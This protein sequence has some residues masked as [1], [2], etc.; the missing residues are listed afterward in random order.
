MNSL[1]R[2]CALTN[3]SVPRSFQRI[4][5][6][7]RS[8]SNVPEALQPIRNPST[9]TSPDPAELVS[10][11]TELDPALQQLQY[12]LGIRTP[13]TTKSQTWK[14]RRDELMDQNVRIEKRRNMYVASRSSLKVI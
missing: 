10:E 2:R 5:D 6:S 8:V 1:A 14:E 9:S 4:L 7:R 12:P 13:P 11:A 3:I